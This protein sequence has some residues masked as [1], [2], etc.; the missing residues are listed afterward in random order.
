V[1]RLGQSARQG[2]DGTGISAGL[3]SVQHVIPQD[4]DVVQ[5]KQASIGRCMAQAEGAYTGQVHAW[6]RDL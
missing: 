3:Q 2:T 4:T 5:H 1:I 6:E